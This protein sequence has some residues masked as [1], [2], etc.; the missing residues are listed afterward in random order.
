MSINLY[1]TNFF[2]P[3]IYI[4]LTLGILQNIMV[5]VPIVYT[6]IYVVRYLSMRT[7]IKYYEKHPDQENAT[8]KLKAEQDAFYI[9]KNSLGK[10]IAI[11]VIFIILTIGLEIIKR[12]VKL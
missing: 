11:D 9:H 6:I 12:F 5:I 10:L 2:I 7:N 3:K 1:F 4:K 8:T